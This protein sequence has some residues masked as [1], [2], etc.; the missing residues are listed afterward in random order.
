M[1]SRSSLFISPPWVRCSSFDSFHSQIVVPECCIPRTLRVC[2][3]VSSV[4][5][6]CVVCVWK[7]DRAVPCRGTLPAAADAPASKAF[8]MADASLTVTILDVVQQAS[9]YKQLRKGANEGMWCSVWLVA[10]RPCLSLLS[11]L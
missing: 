8:P 6:V 7:W 5:C 9:N 1:V 3:F 10:C 2:A 4:S 11:H